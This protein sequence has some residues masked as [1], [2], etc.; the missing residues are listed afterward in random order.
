MSVALAAPSTGYVIAAIAVA[1]LITLALRALPF[2]ALKPLRKSRFVQ[3]LGRWMPAG[4]LL[5]LAVVVLGG[6]LA[7][8]P[9][10]VWPVVIATGVTVAVHLLARRRALLSIAAGTACYVLLLAVW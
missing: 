10:W 9:E 8:R 6:E 4:I 7:G 2:A 5:I 3:S 1:G